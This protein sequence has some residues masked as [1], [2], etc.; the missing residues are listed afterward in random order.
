MSHVFAASHET[1]MLRRAELYYNLNHMLPLLKVWKKTARSFKI[2]RL[3]IRR[4]QESHQNILVSDYFDLWVRQ[5]NFSSAIRKIKSEIAVSRHF[6]MW[7]FLIKSIFDLDVKMIALIKLRRLLYMKNSLKTWVHALNL[8]NQYDEMPIDYNEVIMKK[9]FNAFVLYRRRAKREKSQVIN[10]KQI[11]VFYYKSSY[12]SQWRQRIRLNR[13]TSYY[14]RRENNLIKQSYFVTWIK[15]K[16]IHKVDRIETSKFLEF[17]TD[18]ILAKGFNRWIDNLLTNKGICLNGEE[19]EKRL[20]L[21]MKHHVIRKWR[22]RY[23]SRV[24][25]RIMIE[26]T[27]NMCERHRIDRCFDIWYEKSLK[28]KLEKD[29]LKMKVLTYELCVKRIYFYNMLEKAKISLDLKRKTYQFVCLMEEKILISIFQ[30]WISKFIVVHQQTCLM[31]KVNEYRQNRLTRVPFNVLRN[32]VRIS[33]IYKIISQRH[34]KILQGNIIK[35]WRRTNYIRQRRIML[36]KVSIKL[37]AW[38]CEKTF[39]DKWKEVIICKNKY[40]LNK[41]LAKQDF[42]QMKMNLILNSFIS[43]SKYPVFA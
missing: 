8:K 18:Q 20:L 40:K 16:R 43:G 32:S 4:I 1:Q 22:K 21:K 19:L 24:N 26:T 29:S 39:L 33:K 2:I 12:F 37:W 27:K 41:K 7:R 42:F 23:L 34:D 15:N 17:K 35:E 31:R 5:Y 11:Q 28:I 3:K 6:Q 38:H 9:C 36:I 14:K 30:Y 13:L 10:V 25:Q